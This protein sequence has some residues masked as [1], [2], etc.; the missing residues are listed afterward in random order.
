VRG[1]SVRAKLVRVAFGE[2]ETDAAVVQ[3]DAG[4]AGDEPRSEAHAVRLDERDRRSLLV[5]GTQVG[6]AAGAVRIGEVGDRV[7]RDAADA[8]CKAI[9]VDERLAVCAIEEHGGAIIGR[10]GVPRAKRRGL[11]VPAKQRT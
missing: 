5:D 10:L 11:G 3:P 8:R 4:V 9:G 7:G 2:G 1:A 6:R